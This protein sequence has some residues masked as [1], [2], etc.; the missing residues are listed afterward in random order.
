MAPGG[1]TRPTVRACR[2][3]SFRVKIMIWNAARG[4]MR[5]VVEGYLADGFIA[6]QDIRLIHSYAD[7]GFAGRQL[8]LAKALARYTWLLFTRKVE[9]V[10]CHAAMKGSFWRK[11]LFARLARLRGIPVVLH[12][13]GSEMQPFYERQNG[14]VRQAIQKELERADTV[15]VLSES[16]RAF[17]SAIAP[18]AR[19]AVVPNYVGVPPA[20]IRPADAAPTLL[21]LGAVG[22]R[23]GIFDLL[24][25]LALAR[26]TVPGLRLVVGGNGQVAEAE[27]AAR[28]LGLGEHVDFLGW[29]DAAARARLLQSAAIYVLPSYN[30]GLPMSVLEAM[31]AG[32]PT[33]TTDVGGLPELV[34]PGVDGILVKPGAVDALAAAITSLAGDPAERE[35]MGAAARARVQSLYSRDVVL[36]ALAAVYASAVGEGHRR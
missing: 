13:H 30:E 14:P 27:A 23:K 21:F 24:K 16:W 2:Q 36:R 4:G 5:S 33:V 10:H 11:S 18:R 9:L 28:D 29:V 31:A 19:L 35:R 34:T 15:I 26:K 6:E 8:V 7:G 22:H 1:R 25:A 17:V 32:L 3:G 20:T 12:L